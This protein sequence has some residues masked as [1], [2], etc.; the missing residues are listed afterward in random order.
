MN[1]SP[2]DEGS[3]EPLHAQL[4]RLFTQKIDSGEWPPGHR[5][6]GENTFT[7]RYGVSR[8]TVR[9][10]IL[11]LVNNGYLT[12]KQGKGTFVS[13][14]K[15]DMNVLQHLAIAD[16]QHELLQVDFE[17]TVP[18]VA[19]QMGLAEEQTFTVIERLRLL[20]GEPV[21]LEVSHIPSSI[22]PSIPEEDFALPMVDILRDNHDVVINR[23]SAW[24][25]PVAL[26]RQQ[27]DHLQY[28]ARPALGLLLTR[29]GFIA[30]GTPVT[31]SNSTFRGDKCRAL[32]NQ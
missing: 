11:A 24:I 17:S 12:R 16:T 14:Q 7:T 1:K 3:S 25:E 28:K 32:I 5:L 29:M 30:D 31:F 10:A 13:S 19:R 22:C 9:Q 21:A 26:D 4:Q 15:H 2:L 27:R 20:K 8:S 18:D 23:Y 6:D